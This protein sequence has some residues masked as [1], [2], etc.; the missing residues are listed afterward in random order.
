[1]LETLLAPDILLSLM[2]YLHNLFVVHVTGQPSVPQSSNNKKGV[3]SDQGDYLESG[4]WETQ[5]EEFV[6]EG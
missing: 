5:I 2:Q 6:I 3:A 4:T 1:M